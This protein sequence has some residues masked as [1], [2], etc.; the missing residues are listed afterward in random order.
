MRRAIKAGDRVRTGVYV[1]NEWRP[2]W[3]GEVTSISA[4]GSLATVDIGSMH[5][6]AANM[7]LEATWDLRHEQEA[8]K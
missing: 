8:I 1:C 3:L 2:M 4:D 5:G 7:I 6:C